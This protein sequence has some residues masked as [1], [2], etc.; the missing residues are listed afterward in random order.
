MANQPLVKMQFGSHVYGTNL[1]TS[2]RD[3][4]G[5]FIP[6]AQDLVMQRASKHIRNSTKTDDSKRNTAED[7]DDELFSFQTYME[8]IRQGQTVALDMLFTPERF[9]C[10]DIPVS[11]F[12]TE[13]VDNRDKLV[14]K[15]TNAFVG[16]TK[17]QAAKYGHK[18]ERLQAL[19]AFMNMSEDWIGHLELGDYATEIAA[20]VKASNSKEVEITFIPTPNGLGVTKEM[21]H[22]SLA[23]KKVGYT[24]SVTYARQVWQLV[25]D[26]YGH[27]AKLAESNDGIDWKATMH[28]VRIAA[29]AKEL[30]LTGRLTFPRPEADLLLAIRTGSL[31][32]SEVETLIDQGLKDIEDAE[33]L[34][35]LPNKPNHTLMDKLVSNAHWSA[36]NA[37]SS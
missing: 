21:P 27:R 30:L 32:Y 10:S 17:A 2:D 34:S 31:P 23:N 20:L 16:Y 29:E 18:G 7:V 12:W 19:N 37:A 36:L 1:P 11:P 9:Y 26:K 24:C 14:H 22:L 28:A 13:I 8:L 15:G 33:L 25:L 3:F 5:V 6:D 4:K 35:K